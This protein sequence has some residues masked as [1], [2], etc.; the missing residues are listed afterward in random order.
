MKDF[1]NAFNNQLSR[2]QIKY[3][4]LKLEEEKLIKQMGAGRTTLYRLNEKIDNT[5]NITTQFI[6]RL[7]KQNFNSPKMQLFSPKTI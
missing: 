3:L 6:E 4:I 5:Q 2:G 1:V 7:S